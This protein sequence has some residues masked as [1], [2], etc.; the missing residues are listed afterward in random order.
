MFRV[1]VEI[2]VTDVRNVP[3]FGLNIFSLSQNADLST[4]LHL[5]KLGQTNIVVHVTH[6]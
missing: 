3:G 2:R 5:Y 1:L 6:R 4:S